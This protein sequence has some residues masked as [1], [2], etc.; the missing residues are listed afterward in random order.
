MKDLRSR[1]SCFNPY[2][3]LHR[4]KDNNVLF[5]GACKPNLAEIADYQD[6]TTSKVLIV[7]FIW[8]KNKYNTYWDRTIYK[9]FSFNCFTA[10]KTHLQSH[11]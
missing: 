4:V 8:L 9:S 3:V 6:H 2:L 7:I 1:V 10:Y 5:T 11:T